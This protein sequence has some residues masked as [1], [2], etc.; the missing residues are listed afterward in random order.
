MT[1]LVQGSVK[2]CTEEDV[3]LIAQFATASFAARLAASTAGGTVKADDVMSDALGLFKEL[4]SRFP[5]A[6]VVVQNFS[7]DPKRV[8]ELHLIASD[9]QQSNTILEGEVSRLNEKIRHKN[10]LALTN[11][12][13]EDTLRQELAQTQVNLM[14][15]Q[16]RFNGLDQDRRDLIRVCRLVLEWGDGKGVFSHLAMDIRNLLKKVEAES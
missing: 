2:L 7:D 12:M 9:L 4:R 8:A 6:P 13:V 10:E 16:F 3:R 5:V 15:L 14:N 1:D 11:H